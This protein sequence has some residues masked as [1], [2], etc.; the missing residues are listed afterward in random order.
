MTTGAQNTA[1]ASPVVRAVM[2][3]EFRFL[4]GTQYVSSMNINY[5]WNAILWTGLGALGAVSPIVESDGMEAQA[6]DFTLN[7]EQ[8]SWLAL[9][10]GD[11]AE[12]RGRKAKLYFCPLDEQQRLIDTPELCWSGIMDVLSMGVEKDEGKILLRCET[13]GSL[14]RR[15]S[16]RINAAQQK[17]RH[18]A[19]TGLDYL[20]DLIAKPQL[21]LTKRFQ[22]R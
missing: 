2:F 5:T 8:L 15:P 19:D 16:L 12:Y 17:S 22:E 7:A 13:A 10:V 11:V 9:A 18:P 6:V 3:A 20:T 4:S 21:W 1:L 14:K